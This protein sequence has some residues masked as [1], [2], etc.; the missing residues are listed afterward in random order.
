ML[1]DTVI[2]IALSFVRLLSNQIN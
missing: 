1:H 2:A